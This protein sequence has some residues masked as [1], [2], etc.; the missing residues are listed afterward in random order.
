MEQFDINQAP[1]EIER[2]FLIEYPN[3]AVLRQMPGYHVVHMEQSYLREEG[4]L[5]GGRV[6]R[7]VDGDS[8]KY[9]YTY[10]VRISEM[11]RHEFEKEITED[12]YR[13]MLRHQTPGTITIEKDRHRFLYQGLTYELDVYAFW[14]D[15][16][17][18]EAEVDSEDTPI[19]IP[20]CVTL[21]KE[22]TRDRRYNNSQLSH[23]KGNIE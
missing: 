22:V 9:V 18:L 14:D 16:A 12:E 11:T 21:I 2:K 6:R 15:K 17:T 23:N 13:E 10:K 8:V 1:L 3:F 7:I 19:P 20:P 5:P 4:D